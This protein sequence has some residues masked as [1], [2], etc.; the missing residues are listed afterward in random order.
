VPQNSTD[1]GCCVPT[2]TWFPVCHAP[3]GT[4]AFTTRFERVAS[5]FGGQ[6]SIQ[7]SYANSRL[8]GFQPLL[9]LVQP[10]TERGANVPP[11]FLK[12]FSH[13]RLHPLDTAPRSNTARARTSNSFTP[14]VRPMTPKT[15]ANSSAT[16]KISMPSLYPSRRESKQS[17]RDSNPR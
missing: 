15:I 13:R 16:T 6:R 3:C 11:S 10:I 8:A 5:A 4:M 14:V 2:L 12:P 7:L 9:D 1:E 17:V